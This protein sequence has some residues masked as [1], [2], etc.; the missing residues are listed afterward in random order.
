MVGNYDF[1]NGTAIV[2][3]S[4]RANAKDRDHRPRLQRAFAPGTED[5]AADR[6]A[7]QRPAHVNQ[8]E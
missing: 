2:Q 1:A 7:E 8:D 4:S 6:E 3:H 5:E